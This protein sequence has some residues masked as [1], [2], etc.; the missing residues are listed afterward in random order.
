MNATI[1]RIAFGIGAI[2]IWLCT[3]AV[4]VSGVRK[5]RKSG[6]PD[7]RLNKTDPG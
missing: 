7:L 6:S 3:L 1:G 5:L 2:I 4:V